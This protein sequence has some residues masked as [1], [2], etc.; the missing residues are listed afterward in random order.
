[1]Y[2]QNGD[3]SGLGSIG[4]H[5]VLDVSY[6]YVIISSNTYINLCKGKT[7]HDTYLKFDTKPNHK[8]KDF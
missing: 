3:K 8:K 7:K 5:R 4:P 6:E 1:M 2:M